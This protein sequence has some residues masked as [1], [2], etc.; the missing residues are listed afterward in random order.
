MSHVTYELMN[1]R[2]GKKTVISLDASSRKP[3]SRAYFRCAC[4]VRCRVYCRVWLQNL[5]QCVYAAC[6]V[7]CVAVHVAGCVRAYSRCVCT[8]YDWSIWC[9]THLHIEWL[10]WLIHDTIHSLQIGRFPRPIFWVTARLPLWKTVWNFWDS[11]K[12]LF[13]SYGDSCENLLTCWHS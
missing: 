9:V 4:S 7:G 3:T 11:R 2:R 10:D 5:L 12:D 6:V 13:E 1:N 8:H